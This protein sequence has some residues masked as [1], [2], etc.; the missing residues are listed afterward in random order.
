MLTVLVL[1]FDGMAGAVGF[2][3]ASVSIPS[4]NP[5]TQLQNNVFYWSDGS[6]MAS[7]GQVNR[8][9]VS[10]SQIPSDVQWERVDHAVVLSVVGGARVPSEALAACSCPGEICHDSP[11]PVAHGRTETAGAAELSCA[12]GALCPRSLP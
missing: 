3:Y 1:L 11:G 9:N 6:Q 12:S 7:V 10:L 2:A 4:V 8:Q 5:N